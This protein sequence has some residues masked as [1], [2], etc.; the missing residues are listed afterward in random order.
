MPDVR[1]VELY[2]E[3]EPFLNPRFF[4]LAGRVTG[5]GL[6]A[7]VSTNGSLYPDRFRAVR[8]GK[9]GQV[10]EGIRRLRPRR[11]ERASAGC[12]GITASIEPRSTDTMSRLIDL[13]GA[14]GLDGGL[15]YQPL[16]PA[17]SYADRYPTRLRGEIM[18]L[19][20]RPTS[21]PR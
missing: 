16:N 9:L 19:L 8:T 11:Q 15:G 14:L 10:L 5:R 17:P 12:L 18:S 7:S 2:G 21:G 6:R 4:E 20:S 13:C 3:G 1:Y